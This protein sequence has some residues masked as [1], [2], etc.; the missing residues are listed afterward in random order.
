MSALRVLVTTSLGCLALA[1]CGAAPE[2]PFNRATTAAPSTTV[3]C[4]IASLE[5]ALHPAIDASCLGAPGGCEAHC[6]LG[7]GDACMYLG[8]L[9]RAKRLVDGR[10]ATTWFAHACKK[11]VAEG[12]TETALAIWRDPSERGP[13][14]R[15]ERD[16]ECVLELLE[17]ACAVRERRACDLLPVMREEHPGIRRVKYGWVGARILGAAS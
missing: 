15:R 2:P 4:G 10:R 5:L 16:L 7:V 1:A 9:T 12:C 8:H 6:E 17:Q 3:S 14:E 13:R 11:G